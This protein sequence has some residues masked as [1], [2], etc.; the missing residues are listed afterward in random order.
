M[1]TDIDVYN[2]RMARV[3]VIELNNDLKGITDEL[4]KALEGVH[5]S[6]NTPERDVGEIS[7]GGGEGAPG[8]SR[9]ASVVNGS[10]AAEAVSE[11]ERV[12]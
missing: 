12:L 8:F 6:L 4:A 3:R 5:G 9:V 11:M 10:P 2:V 7:V 1:I